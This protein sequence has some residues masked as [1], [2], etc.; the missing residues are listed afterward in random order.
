MTDKEFLEILNTG[1]EVEAGSPVHQHMHGLSQR[2][3][4]ITHQMNDSYRTPEELS[5]LMETLTMQKIEGLG[6]FPPFNTDCGINIHI[7]RNVFINSGCK[8]QD[9]GGIYI[10]DDVL[11]GHNVVL[12]TLNHNLNPD[13]RGNLIPAPIHIG[14]KVWIGSNSTILAGVS[15]GNSAVI[16]AGAVVNCDVPENCVY[17]GVPA[18]FI[19][20]V[21]EVE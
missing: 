16:A 19:K 4:K 10:G 5:S 15:I 18:K 12:A 14:N 7:G 2:A 13:K 1:K 8:F 3:L 17:G 9:H 6:L 11:I 20:K 21:D